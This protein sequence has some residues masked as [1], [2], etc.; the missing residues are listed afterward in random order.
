MIDF[1]DFVAGAISAPRDQNRDLRNLNT[2][3]AGAAPASRSTRLAGGRGRRTRISANALDR[4][5]LKHNELAMVLVSFL[6]STRPARCALT[7]LIG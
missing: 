1:S 6:S 4:R 5:S 3:A 7:M 2:I